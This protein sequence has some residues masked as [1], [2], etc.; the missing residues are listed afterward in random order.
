MRLRH[1]VL[2]LAALIAA[3][4]VYLLRRGDEPARL[5]APAPVAASEI[6]RIEIARDQET[7]TL[8]RAD[9]AWRIAPPGVAA[10]RK[11]VGQMLEAL[12]GLRLS[13][14]VAETPSDALYELDAARRIRVRAWA[15]ERPVR[16]LS[17]GKIAPSFRHTFVRLE[18]DA[19]VFHA[20]DAFR[21]RFARTLEDMRD[22]TVLAFA[23]GEIAELT[24]GRGGRTIALKRAPAAAEGAPPAWQGADGK[25]V[26]PAAVE[27]L[28]RRLSALACDRF[29]AE[30]GAAD[31][32][33]PVL[34]VALAGAKTHRLEL[35]APLPG[36]EE[37]SA[38]GRSS[39]AAEPFLL[40]DHQAAPLFQKA[41][42][43]LSAAA[44]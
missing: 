20:V 4:S 41:D 27:E 30:A 3:L 21:D 36:S 19:R 37:K 40:A 26:D 16:D 17:I 8:T 33:D 44:P 1:K 13:A 2:I 29:L 10:D 39:G 18:G 14:V 38:P 34:T 6:T 35:F 31:L 28:L 11:L 9:D 25:A 22:K 23:P 15:G 7:L 42:E 12:A 32:R 5:P 43:I 24:I